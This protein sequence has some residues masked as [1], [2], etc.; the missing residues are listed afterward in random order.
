MPN[1][2]MSDI[3]RLPCIFKRGRHYFKPRSSERLQGEPR[4]WLGWDLEWAEIR[5]GSGDWERA[6]SRGKATVKLKTAKQIGRCE[7]SIELTNE[8]YL[9]Q[10]RRKKVR[11]EVGSRPFEPAKAM[12]SIEA[13]SRLVPQSTQVNL[14]ARD[15]SSASEL[16]PTCTCVQANVFH[17]VIYKATTSS[18]EMSK[19]STDI[20]YLYSSFI[21]N[22]YFSK[23]L[24]SL[25]WKIFRK[26]TNNITLLSLNFS[27]L[28]C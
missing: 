15:F 26:V 27:N 22:K 6:N 5:D 21:F 28:M 10:T 2:H 7:G 17:V 4:I 16:D 18:N 8:A 20:K 24:L 11:M 14:Q 13:K 1:C 3:R 25:S 9:G 12:W 19:D 23:W